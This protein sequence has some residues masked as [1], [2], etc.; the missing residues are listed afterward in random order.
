MAGCGNNEALDGLKGLKD[1]MKGLMEQ[2]SG[3]LADLQSKFDD[4]VAKLGEFKPEIPDNPTL[5][6]FIDKLQSATDGTA[7]EADYKEMKEKFGEAWAEMDEKLEEMGLGKFPPSFDA[8]TSFLKKETGVDLDGLLKGDF[9]SIQAKIDAATEAG[10]T[11][12]DISAIL[13]GDYSSLGSE[14]SDKIT[15]FTE[16]PQA[17]ICEN[18]PK[19]ELQE[20]EQKNPET[21]VVEKVKKPFNIAFPATIPVE[22]P[23]FSAASIQSNTSEYSTSFKL[24][25]AARK[26]A[27]QALTKLLTEKVNTDSAYSDYN[28]DD[29]DVVIRI[30]NE[31]MFKYYAEKHAEIMGITYKEWVERRGKGPKLGLQDIKPYKDKITSYLINAQYLYNAQSSEY[32]AKTEF[33]KKY[34]DFYK[35]YFNNMFPVEEFNY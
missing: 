10:E 23:P 19:V 22:I 18:I 7:F 31:V 25:V 33:E 8:T 30:M 1:D 14:V 21:G 32:N 28:D 6:D 4:A 5:Q 12:P 24:L 17:A 35:D 26:N 16:D 29:K 20:V 27:A 2:G 3:A 34:D 15:K 11:P 9:S 13:S